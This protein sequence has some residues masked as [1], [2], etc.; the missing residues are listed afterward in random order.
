M[1]EVSPSG[2]PPV[3]ALIPHEP[4]ARLLR[5]LLDVSAEGLAGVAEIPADSPFV[6]GGRAPAYLGLEAAAQGAAALEAL[7]RNDAPG[8]RIGYLVGLRNASLQTPWMPAGQPF[9]IKVRLTGSA[10]ALSIYD[11]TI[12]SG[13]GMGLVTGTISTY[14]AS[15]E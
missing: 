11:V 15:Q 9:R 8:P 2:L 5:D 1:P 13:T 12:E 14:I 4:P 3:S 6:T 7:R 10:A